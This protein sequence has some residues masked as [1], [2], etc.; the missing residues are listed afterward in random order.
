MSRI[1][2]PFAGISGVVEYQAT[3]AAGA[4]IDGPRVAIIARM[5]GNEPVGDSVLERLATVTLQRGSVV[6]IRANQAAAELGLRHTPDGSD[7]NRLWDRETLARIRT[8]P[9]D[10]RSYEEN[11]ATEL[12]P[13]LLACDAVLDLHSTSRPSEAFLVFRDDQ[14]HASLARVLGVRRLVTGLHEN[15]IL[16]GGVASNVGLGPGRRSKRLGFTFEAGQHDAAGN[17]ERAWGVTDRLLTELGLLDGSEA[18][19]DT[20]EVY[21]VVDRFPQMP[22]NLEPYRFVGYEGGE[23]GG[24]RR[25]RGRKLHSFETIEADEIVL[26]RGHSEV[27]RAKSPFTMLM[28]APTT[29]PGTDLYYVTQPRHGGLAEGVPRTD[30][31]ARTEALAIERMLDLLADDEFATGSSWVAFD[32]RR[33]FDLCASIVARSLRLP[34]D[35]PHRRIAVMGRGD[36]GGAEG[37]RRIGHRYRQAMRTAI[38]D[39]LPIERIQLM[40]GASLRWID[41]LTGERLQALV[42]RRQARFEGQTPPVRLRFSVRQPHTASLLVAGDLDHALETGDVRHVRVALLI[43]AATVEPVDGTARLRVQRTGIVSARHEVIEAAHGL[44]GTLR[45]EHRDQ[46]RHGVLRD[47]PI[48]ERLRLDDDAI[49]AS[50]DGG[51]LTA[52]RGALRRVQYRLWC[53]QILGVLSQPVV[54][55][56]GAAL[57][58]WLAR[59][60]AQTGILDPDA[61]HAMAVVPDGRGF[62]ADPDRVVSFFDDITESESPPGLLAV[63]VPPAPPPPQPLFADQVDADDLERW[64]GWK[65]FVRGVQVVP[66]TRGKDLDLAFDLR[67]IRARLVRWFDEARAAAARAP[68]SIQLVV[69]GDGLNPRRDRAELLQGMYEA[70]RRALLDENVAYLRIQHAQGTHLS[71]MK[72]FLADCRARSPFGAPLDLQLEAEHGATVNVVLVLERDPRVT[73]PSPQHPLDGWIIERC[74]VILA[75]VHRN[76][77]SAPLAWFTEVQDGTVNQ[78]L[79]HFG[80]AHCEGLWLH[81]KQLACS[82]D[83]F[84]GALVEQIAGWIEHARLWN[85]TSGTVPRDTEARARWVAKRLGLFD[86]RLARL[87]AREMDESKPAAEAARAIWEAVPSWPGEGGVLGPTPGDRASDAPPRGRRSNGP[88]VPRTTPAPR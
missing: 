37:E 73:H 67:T 46:I 77:G 21:E 62:V 38:R 65:R 58:R 22:A 72:D 76:E 3:D 32:A 51:Q 41:A 25:G 1:T 70:H 13:I 27:V 43:E 79:L 15:S 9:P 61:I 36:A 10:A 64:V 74:G 81:G 16:D 53:D 68:G 84:E 5:H 23:P 26:R 19:A 17:A 59:T 42:S 83:E 87:L 85:R 60:M 63:P 80:R 88:P 33:L 11:R 30:E 55:P 66:D 56:D 71:W 12:A 57:G 18:P 31:T 14:R 44:L 8:I 29:D 82:I 24:G 4:P 47:E 20:G 49:E 75:D 78:E 48:I 39:G 69:A 7:L 50:A 6:A 28:P 2:A 34:A 45:R 35:H 54:L 86:A 40:R 52:L